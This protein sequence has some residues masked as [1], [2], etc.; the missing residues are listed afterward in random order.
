[1]T[2]KPNQPREPEVPE[3]LRNRRQLSEDE[4]FCFGCHPGVPCFG[5]CC[6]DVSIMLGP[7]DVLRLA[8]KLGL[9]TKDFLDAHTIIP[10][11]KQLHLPVVLLKMNEDEDRRCP[12]VSEEGCTVYEARP[13][14]CRM[15]PVMSALP[16]GHAGEKAKPVYYLAEDDFCK[17]HSEKHEWTV[18]SY[19]ANQKAEED[20]IDEAFRAVVS[21]PWFIGG[22]RQLNPKQIELFYMGAYD[23]DAFRRFVFDSTFLKRFDVDDTLVEKIREDDEELLRFSLRWLRFAMFGENTV[24]VRESAK[25]DVVPPPSGDD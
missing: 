13:W 19:R 17:G 22:H 6:G 24:A 25:M 12:F 16:P 4:P 21:H 1:M 15:Y 10:I 23:V 9:D 20:D 8:R 7:K 11:T 2:K 18:A 3:D 5:T 14:S